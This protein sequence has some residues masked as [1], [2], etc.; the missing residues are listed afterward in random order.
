LTLRIFRIELTR[1]VLPTPGPPLTT[2][3]FVVSASRTASRWLAASV[4]PALL[5]TQGMAFAA[6]IAGQGRTP[7]LNPLIRAA[8]AR[9][10]RCSPARK[11]QGSP[12]TLSPVTSPS[13]SSRSSAVSMILVGTSD[14]LTAMAPAVPAADRSGPPPSLR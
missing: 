3:T 2:S 7:P 13:C 1:V 12:S 4:T 9:S 8:I 11:M 10:A 6:S 14:S 5:S